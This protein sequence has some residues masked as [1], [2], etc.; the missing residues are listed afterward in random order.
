VGPKIRI[1]SKLKRKRKRKNVCHL[2][3]VM[4]RCPLH[5]YSW[6]VIYWLQNCGGSG[7]SAVGNFGILLHSVL[8]LFA[9]R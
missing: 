9:K 5:L 1:I 6:S 4:S 7:F 2:D 3:R 8:V